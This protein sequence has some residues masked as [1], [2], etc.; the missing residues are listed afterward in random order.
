MPVAVKSLRQEPSKVQQKVKMLKLDTQDIQITDS[1]QVIDE[2]EPCYLSDDHWYMTI[3]RN[4]QYR[5]P[6][7]LQEIDKLIAADYDTG[8]NTSRLT[9]LN[10]A[11]VEFYPV[12]TYYGHG[13]SYARLLRFAADFKR[14]YPEPFTRCFR[15]EYT[16]LDPEQPIPKYSELD[17]ITGYENPVFFLDRCFT[18]REIGHLEPFTCI[19]HQARL[20]AAE[21]ILEEYDMLDFLKRWDRMSHPLFVE[22]REFM[23]QYGY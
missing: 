14:A 2:R 22:Y 11:L 20:R 13:D 10:F 16:F 3:L 7:M 8:R 4:R 18:I 19:P 17:E 5:V 15:N 12:L 21:S 9:K 1:S 6:Q 23:E